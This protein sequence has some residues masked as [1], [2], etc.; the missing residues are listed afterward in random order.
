MFTHVSR[1]STSIVPSP[2]D[3]SRVSSLRTQ[4]VARLPLLALVL[5][6]AGFLG[7]GLA[8]AWSDA[9]TFDEP[10]Y[11]AAGIAGVLH[12]DVTFNDEHPPLPKVLAALPVLLAHP[13]IPPNGRWSGN[14]EQS[15]AS[16]FVAAQLA[17]GTLRRVTFASRLVPLA[18][19]AG[20]AFVLFALGA[21][22]FGPGAGALAGALWLAAP[23]VLGIGHLDGVD[24]PFSLTTA[25]SAW[26][27]A[28][29]LRSRHTRGL[30]WV[31]LALGAVAITQISG[32]LIVAGSLAVILAVEWRAGIQRAVARTALTGLVALIAIWASYV[33]LTPSVIWK[34]PSVLPRPYL[35]GV[36]YLG[37][38]DTVGTTGYVAGIAYQGGRW[39]FWPVS[40]V[41]KWPAASLL[42][43]VAG[44]AVAALGWRRLS[45]GVPSRLAGAVVL[46]AAL[47]TAFT[48]TMPRDIGLRYLL[49]VMALWAVLA[50]A[51]VPAVTALR[52]RPR[53]LAQAS[54]AGLLTLA[55][56][57]TIWSFPNSLAW[58]TRPFR[59]AYRAV[60]DSNI[61]W[62]QGLYAL[63][64]WS[65]RHHPWIA[66]FGPR[67]ITPAAIPGARA[68]PGTAPAG[69]SGWV[70]VSVTA[71]NSS[72]R[73]SLAWLR[74]WC[75]VGVLD[76]SILLYRF[77]EPPLSAAP[78]PVQPPALCPG[79]WSSVR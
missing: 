1:N 17:A 45:P 52:P 23:F 55:L 18:E 48:L 4:S 69:I 68:L 60:T 42:L 66:Y 27:L 74:R 73:S 8:E 77:R 25:L 29:W 43:L 46:P 28:R 59:P 54:V 31:G 65:E 72:N 57:A 2:T 78:I 32:L 47:L 44:T 21:E 62:G 36:S 75:P 38:Q 15:Y 40:L 67:G 30:I 37:S 64:A 3:V 34:S 13:V 20:V 19:S 9:P 51:L 33:V 14:D 63:S 58:T 49:P 6:V 50:G 53:H 41:I 7:L 56:L 12:H 5:L 61:D 79:P 71:L 24:I 70:A 76:G 11:V 22:L 16:R 10:V 26:A 35:D 39:W